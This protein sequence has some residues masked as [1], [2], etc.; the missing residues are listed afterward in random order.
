MKTS[1]SI[2][3]NE[4][5]KNLYDPNERN[6]QTPE[7]HKLIEDLLDYLRFDGDAKRYEY[8]ADLIEHFKIMFVD[9][10]VYP[11][12]TASV[13][14]DSNPKTIRLSTGFILPVDENE[15][16]L[17]QLSVLLRHEMA[18]A[19]MKHQMRASNEYIARFGDEGEKRIMKSPSLMD[20]N[21]IVADFEISNRRYT[22]ED[23]KI[24]QNMKMGNRIIGGL[25]TE[26]FRSD[27]Q[28]L[29][30]EEMDRLLEQ[31]IKDQH[32]LMLYMIENN[33]D[34]YLKYDDNAKLLRLANQNPTL[35]S[36]VKAVDPKVKTNIANLDTL[37]KDANQ[38]KW[39]EIYAN[40]ITTVIPEILKYK[41]NLTEKALTYCIKAIG[42]TAPLEK[43][44]FTN[45]VDGSIVYELYTPEEKLLAI[46]ILKCAIDDLNAFDRWKTEIETVLGNNKYTEADI[47]SIL[48]AL[49][50]N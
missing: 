33:D 17:A 7:E 20:L 8:Y 29:S 45:P 13:S 41:D 3:I 6:W 18:H 10:E 19:L 23:K 28:T 24:V 44:Y 14:F 40:L 2:T 30:L 15:R 31:Y 32:Y 1:H 25:V 38:G 43:T 26:E 12:F 16:M 34:Y 36:Y 4:A 27:W 46:D 37:L 39:P 49:E 35:Y 21:N 5:V 42:Q 48:S 9:A 50:G 47:K 22:A 11:N